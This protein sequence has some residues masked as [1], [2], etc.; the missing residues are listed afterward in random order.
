MARDPA[1]VLAAAHERWM[2]NWNF[3]SGD[4][5]DDLDRWDYCLAALDREGYEVRPKTDDHA[6][7]EAFVRRMN[8]GGFIRY[9]LLGSI[10]DDRPWW[11]VVDSA[12]WDAFGPTWR[13]ATPGEA[14]LFDR[15]FDPPLPT[16]PVPATDGDDAHTDHR[17]EPQGAPDP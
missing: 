14:A 6:A 10:D 17:G 4:R 9:Q 11:N 3:H 8:R 5:L 7:A 1:T 13:D 2:N 16:R 12:T 15:L